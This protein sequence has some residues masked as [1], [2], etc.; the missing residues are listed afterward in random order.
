MNE[1]IEFIG[2]CLLLRSTKTLVIG[3]LHLGYENVLN[4]SGILISR[5]MYE[6]MISY[7]DDVFEKTGRV[8]EVVLLGD[9][10][11]DFGSIMKQEW[12]DVKKLFE[13]LRR[14]IVEKGKIIVVKGNHDKLIQ[15]IIKNEEKVILKECYKKGEYVFVHGDKDQKELSKL[16]NNIWIMGHFHP[17]IKISEG[18]KSEKYKC[19]LD[20]KYEGKRVIVLP[21][22]FELIEGSDPRDSL[23]YSKWK[24]KFENFDVIVVGDNLRTF[25]FGKLKTI[26]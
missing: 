20:G 13:Y 26:G 14:K 3:D 8:N 11:H 19:F 2:K 5:N 10:K 1:E 24:F 9:V 23:V 25:N 6:E 22:F 18:V 7:L 16:D 17:A 12:E 4:S 21:S 15:P